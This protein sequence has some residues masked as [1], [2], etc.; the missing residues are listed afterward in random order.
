MDVKCNYWLFPIP[1]YKEMIITPKSIEEI[2]N[3]IGNNSRDISMW[4]FKNMNNPVL[5]I[6]DIEED[7]F[8]I[9]PKFLKINNS[10]TVIDSVKGFFLRKNGKTVIVLKWKG[11]SSPV[12]QLFLFLIILCNDS[13]KTAFYNPSFWMIIL[14]I[15]ML[16]LLFHWLIYRD[17]FIKINRLILDEK[18][19][20]ALFWKK[21][22]NWNV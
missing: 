2:K 3:I 15:C 22:E 6:S 17:L 16:V 19:D 9:W 14:I 8:L 1:V 18:Y 10:K 7:S 4:S 5:F 11:I 21:D 12:I 13:V 20:E